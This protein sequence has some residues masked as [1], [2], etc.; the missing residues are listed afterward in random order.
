MN[1]QIT[2]KIKEKIQNKELIQPLLFLSQN[3]ELLSSKIQQQ[4]HHLFESFWADKNN[5]YI[6][7]DNGE[8]IKT[9]QMRELIA[10]W[11]MKSSFWF[12]IFL[13]ENIS[14]ATPESL[15]SALKFFE[16]PGLGNIIILTNKDESGILDTILSRVQVIQWENK[17]K[18]NYSEFYL[19][20]IEDY[21]W[22]KKENLIKYFFQD[23]KIEK[24][25]YLSFFETFLHFITL[26]PEYGYLAENIENSLQ[27]IEKNNAIP[28]YEIDK[29][30]LNI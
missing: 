9:A 25:D 19:Q 2:Q 5:F 29:L 15:N 23:K 20:L 3:Q 4:S 22:W 14:R 11:N 6:L 21:F 24:P 30:L 26:H 12:Q 28:K 7:P 27:I 10:K 16:E 13:I 17:S 1:E 18:N 8:K